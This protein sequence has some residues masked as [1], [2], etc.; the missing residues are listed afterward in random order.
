M[1]D[2]MYGDMPEGF[3]GDYDWLGFWFLTEK[4]KKVFFERVCSNYWTISWQGIFTCANQLRRHISCDCMLVFTTNTNL[5]I[6]TPLPSSYDKII[7]SGG[8]S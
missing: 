3:D 2:G 5:T 8:A 7:M 6:S 4:Q 1:T